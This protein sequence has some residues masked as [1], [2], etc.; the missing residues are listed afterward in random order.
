MQVE[1]APV[2]YVP[3]VPGHSAPGLPVV[4]RT[5]VVRMVVVRTVVALAAA[6]RS[7]KPAVGSNRRLWSVGP[8]SI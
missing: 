6:V 1:S 3:L 7:A 4:V 2:E 8:M 5:V